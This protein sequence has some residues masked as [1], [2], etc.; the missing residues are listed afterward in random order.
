MGTNE[1]NIH[2]DFYLIFIVSGALASKFSIHPFLEKRK[3]YRS[4]NPLVNSYYD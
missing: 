1:V 2:A 4:Q 3:F